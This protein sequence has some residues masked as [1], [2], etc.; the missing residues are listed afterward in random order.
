MKIIEVANSATLPSTSHTTALSKPGH[1]HG[2]ARAHCSDRGIQ[3]WYRLAWCRASDDDTAIELSRTL[4][5][6]ASALRKCTGTNVW[7]RGRVP[8]PSPIFLP[9]VLFVK[10]SN[11]L[12]GPVVPR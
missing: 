9:P 4:R 10:S 7:I 2:K 8:D 1:G 3:L 11:S 6:A 5:V 12:T